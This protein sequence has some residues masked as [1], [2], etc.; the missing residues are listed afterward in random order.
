MSYHGAVLGVGLWVYRL[1]LVQHFT[2]DD[3]T[4]PHGAN[5]G[6]QRPIL[7]EGQCKGPACQEHI[8]EQRHLE[9]KE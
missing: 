7:T 4:R 2:N 1:Q 8:V 9:R 5:A 6:R 3:D